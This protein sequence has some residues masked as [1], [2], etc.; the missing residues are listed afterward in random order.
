M[1]S[2]SF[3]VFFFIL[4]LKLPAQD[5]VTENQT[6]PATNDPFSV[7]ENVPSSPEM[8]TLGEYGKID[9]SSYN[10]KANISIPISTINFDGLQLPIQLTY[11]SGG[12][13]VAQESGW[14]GLNWE[15]S[16]TFG[17]SRKIYGIDDF[18]NR[19]AGQY[20]DAPLNGYIYNDLDPALQPNESRPYL[21]L[22]DIISVH[23]SF[24]LQSPV[25]TGNRSMDTQP[26][27]FN[28]NVL[29]QSYKFIL[30]KK[31]TTNIIEA[32]VFDN[33]NV[34]ISINLDT[35]NFT[36]IDEQGFTYYFETK[37]VNTTFASYSTNPLG[38]SSYQGAFANVFVE[39]NASGQSLVTN[40]ALDR[41]TSP[42]GRTL[43]FEY[44]PGL[45]FT[46]P[47]YTFDYEGSDWRTKPN[48]SGQYEED[49][50][51]ANWNMSFT[52][53]ENNYLSKIRGDFG[54]VDFLLG[55]REDLATGQTIQAMSSNNFGS[56]ILVTS[57]SQIRSCHGSTNCP[58]SS[59]YLPKKLEGIQVKNIDLDV[60]TD[61]Q[62][63]YGYF[64]STRVNE[65][66]KERYFR[67][68]LEGLS[69][70]DKNYIFS[71]LNSETLAA[72]DS[73]GVDFWGFYN[74]RNNNPGLVPRISRFVN[75]RLT[76]GSTPTGV[77]V[78]LGQVFARFPGADRGSDFNFGKNGLLKTIFYPTGG[79]TT[80]EYEPHDVIMEVPEPF[81][82][83]E[84][85]SG[86]RYKWTNMTNEDNFKI[87]YQYLKCA[88]DASYNFFDKTT[89]FDP[90]DAITINQQFGTLFSVNFPSILEVSSTLSTI[91]NYDGMSF[92]G[93]SPL[94]VVEETNTGREY[95]IFTYG[96][97]NPTQ[98][99]LPLERSKTISLPPGNYRIAQK[100]LNNPGAPAVSLTNSQAL[101]HTFQTIEPEVL[102]DFLERFEVGGA[103][104]NKVV[105]RDGN[106][107]FISSTQY[108]YSYPEGFEGLTSSGVLMDDLIF[109]KKAT[110][111]H[112]YNP[113]GYSSFFLTGSN[114]LGNTPTA[115][116]SHVGYSYVRES[117]VDNQ[118]NTLGSIEK[119]YHNL[120]NEYFK[121]SFCL[122]YQWDLLSGNGD[123][124]ISI[125][126]F[127]TKWFCSGIDFGND[128]AGDQKTYYSQLG[129]ACIENAIVLGIPLRLSYGHINGK[130][131]KERVLD[132]NSNLVQ[133][134]IN[135]YQLLNGNL[136][137]KYFA[138]FINIPMSFEPGQNAGEVL[139][140]LYNTSEGP[141]GTN[142]HTYYPYEFPRHHGLIAKESK[143]IVNQYLE[144]GVVTNESNLLYDTTTHLLESSSLLDSKGQNNTTKYFYP[145]DSESSSQGGVGLLVSENR[146]ANPVRTDRYLNNALQSTQKIHY[147]NNSF[148]SS[149]T[150]PTSVESAKGIPKTTNNTPL[151]ERFLYERYGENGNILQ[152]RTEAGVPVCLIWGHKRKYVVAKIENCTYDQIESL[153][154]F[155]PNFDLGNA[156]LSN[157]LED[158]LRTSLSNSL[159]TTYEHKPMVGI[160]KLTDPKGY[161]TTFTY[162]ENNR[163]KEVR[164]GNNHIVTDY[165]YE[166]LSMTKN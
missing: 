147:D 5:I 88:E 106:G 46:F 90:G 53:I 113:R 119:E 99:S 61:V 62:L 43:Y 36:L 76:T 31:G 97:S 70:N 54:E 110:G 51:K 140:R 75:S 138:T 8:G 142:H 149:I 128:C 30:Q 63:N 125:L 26:D 44:D 112:S 160:T 64:N 151:E 157:V 6:G 83:T 14:A 18:S 130:V 80:F 153:S 135:E 86:G 32:I 136:P 115:Q 126:G 161:T 107:E 50:R 108:S 104:V 47:Q 131:L 146:I 68:K 57:Q 129:D 22:D 96:D 2:I 133:E 166:Y 94:L 100:T 35:M 93:G 16:T 137:S 21:S 79:S 15:I 98:G 66:I 155:G 28:V 20:E 12:V 105:N 141:W 77:T 25:A 69:I 134:T 85:F 95:L 145:Y 3:L 55:D 29:G 48:L 56:N 150:L 39:T 91:F 42:K 103:R 11:D 58:N 49:E 102:S 127:R 1:R 41:I 19:I 101:L 34:K 89:N 52:V 84:S 27:V 117:Q 67:L 144:N 33:N 163:L 124:Y 154:L 114:A 45:H 37:E 162:D 92:W 24:A 158:Q 118:G 123:N 10:G 156:G 165:R 74:G 120:K 60:L 109:H 59:S 65:A 23:H 7:F 159:I 72:K 132:N 17:I 38:N 81:Q 87:T 78:D 143:T 148:T 152:Y 73:Y 122:P 4:F 111:F 13:R 82:V 40:W 139:S 71:Y 164:D 116:G 121:D 9:A